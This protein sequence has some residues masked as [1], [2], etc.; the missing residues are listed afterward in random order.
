MALGD[1]GTLTLNYDTNNLL[2][3][4]GNI[5]MV[6]EMAWGGIDHGTVLW[7]YSGSLSLPTG[8]VYG[9]GLETILFC[10]SGNDRIIVIDRS[11]NPESVS[12]IASVTTD[13][14][15]LAIQ[16]PI[17]C[18]MLN[19]TIYVCEATGRIENFGETASIHPSMARSGFGIA[20]GSDALLQFANMRFM[21]IVRS[22]K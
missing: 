2:I 6:S 21:P 3:S 19:D 4:G 22:I 13:G 12:T 20:S 17:R 14:N 10:D 15:P 5:P 7:N 9:D 11:Y 16:N 18:A 1:N 8:A